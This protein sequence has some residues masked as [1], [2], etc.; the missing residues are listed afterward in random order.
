MSIPDPDI[1]IIPDLTFIVANREDLE[2]PYRV[3]VENDDVTP[4]DFV[5]MVLRLFFGLALNDAMQVMLTA[6][7]QGRALV[8]TM[9]FEEAKERVYSAHTVARE[10][11]YPLTFYLEPDN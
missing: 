3:I 11:G 5:V 4:M 2:K 8:T 9:P 6:H 1:R 10:E 7:H